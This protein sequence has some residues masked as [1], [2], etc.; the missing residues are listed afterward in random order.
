MERQPATTSPDF[1]LEEAHAYCERAWPDWHR[2][3]AHRERD[4]GY[5]ADSNLVFNDA[6]AHMDHLLE[7]LFSQLVIVERVPDGRRT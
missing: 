1:E 2:A 4:G 6:A 5:N 3:F 7:D